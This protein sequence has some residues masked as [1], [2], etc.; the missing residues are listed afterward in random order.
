MVTFTFHS[1]S[2][3]V[4]IFIHLDCYTVRHVT[5]RRKTSPISATRIS[6]LS[7]TALSGLHWKPDCFVPPERKTAA[8]VS[9]LLR[10]PLRGIPGY[11][12]F[13]KGVCCSGGKRC[14]FDLHPSGTAAHFL[15]SGIPEH[16]RVCSAGHCHGYPHGF[17]PMQAFRPLPQPE[18][19]VS[20]SG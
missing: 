4:T 18:A 9:A 3:I 17:S 1:S 20:Q 12:L 6:T 19:S 2:G 11:S 8:P 13:S 14:T 16:S 10:L 7:Y 5:A 15:P